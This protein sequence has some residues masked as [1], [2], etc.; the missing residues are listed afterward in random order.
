[1]TKTPKK[2]RLLIITF[3]GD[4]HANAV[5][6]AIKRLG[7]D[8]DVWYVTDF[9]DYQTIDITVQEDGAVVGRVCGLGYE[10]DLMAATTIWFRRYR[11]PVAPGD[12]HPSDKLII[13]R[14]SESFLKGILEVLPQDAFWINAYHPSI[15]ANHKLVQLLEASNCGLEV[16][17]T[18]FTNDPE[19]VEAAFRQAGLNKKQLIIKSFK[20]LS[21]SRAHTA[22]TFPTT[23][24]DERIFQSS[25]SVSWCPAIYQPRLE[26]LYE[27]RVTV[28]GAKM[29][30]V[31]LN[32]QERHETKID[33]RLMHDYPISVEKVDLPEMVSAKCEQLMR[34]L[35]L[36]FGC[37]DFV[38]TPSGD[39]VFLEINEMG[40]FLWV[41]E[42]C[43]DIP[44][45][46]CFVDFLLTGVRRTSNSAAGQR[47]ISLTDFY[48]DL[49]HQ[50]LL[51][52][53]M[54]SRKP[55]KPDRV[56]VETNSE[57]A[58]G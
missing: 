45:L 5:S 53:D 41:E 57:E 27:V 2:F 54:E 35:G 48:Q 47:K 22:F 24:V 44:I 26:K 13:E 55:V 8:V 49:E 3:S 9:P 39:Y 42:V 19:K 6:W 40:Q 50:R 17:Q 21:W 28:M 30:A 10:I 46:A 31:R 16:V 52:S 14:E 1:M 56:I 20:Q 33:W 25:K 29:V 58:S 34:A 51:K 43:P 23:V 37:I 32:S 38:V 15:R 7:Y 12:S 18:L 4:T 11:K 36:V